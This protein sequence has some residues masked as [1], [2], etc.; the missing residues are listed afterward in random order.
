[1][2]QDT[3]VTAES[4][5]VKGL[6]AATRVM[7]FPIPA[8]MVI[9]VVMIGDVL[10]VILAALIARIAYVDLVHDASVPLQPH[11]SGELVAPFVVM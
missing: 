9:D 10:C 3:K 4:V 1:M 11:G 2:P 7:P 6:P 5:A 8:R